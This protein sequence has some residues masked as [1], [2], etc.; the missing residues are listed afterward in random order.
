MFIRSYIWVLNC[1]QKTNQ[2]IKTYWVYENLILLFEKVFKKIKVFKILF[3]ITSCNIYAFC[4]AGFTITVISTALLFMLLGI[5]LWQ[6]YMPGSKLRYYNCERGRKI[7]HGSVNFWFI[8][9]RLKYV[10]S[11]PVFLKIRFSIYSNFRI[12]HKNDY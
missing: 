4:F 11:Y 10:V 6:L 5:S 2:L 1:F 9:E 8:P 3:Q 12:I 7:P